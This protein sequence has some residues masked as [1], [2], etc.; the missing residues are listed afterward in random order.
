MTSN[1]DLCQIIENQ[2]LQSF[3]RR[4]TFAEYMDRVLYHPQHGYYNGKGKLGAPGDFVTS[5]HLC[6]DFGETLAEQFWEMWQR[7]G[8][9]SIS[10]GRNGGWTGNFSW[11]YFNLYSTKIPGFFSRDRVYYN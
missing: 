9:P 5:V 6:S 1:L 4:I 2:I 11:G 3:Q 10:I 8:S 7:L